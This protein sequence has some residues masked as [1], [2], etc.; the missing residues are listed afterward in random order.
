MQS[1]RDMRSGSTEQSPATRKHGAHRGT[2]K[3]TTLQSVNIRRLG[4]VRLVSVRVSVEKGHTAVFSC[5]Y[6]F[7]IEHM[8]SRQR[9]SQPPVFV[10]INTLYGAGMGLASLSILTA[11]VKAIKAGIWRM[12]EDLTRVYRNTFSFTLQRDS[13][14][15][16]INARRCIQHT[17]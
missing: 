16:Y 17:G 5:T 8:A 10:F 14:S 11:V 7:P 4:V 1:P 2:A 13:T 12:L 9:S 15:H 3:T 6:T